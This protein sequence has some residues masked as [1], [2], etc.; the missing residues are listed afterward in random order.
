MAVGQEAALISDQATKVVDL[1][2]EKVSNWAP[3]SNQYI[4]IILYYICYIYIIL[5]IHYYIYIIIYIYNYLSHVA[6][7]LP[8]PMWI[9]DG[10]SKR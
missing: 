2:W 10:T 8:G 9:F 1:V 3:K 6:L 7:T 4:Y 5:Y